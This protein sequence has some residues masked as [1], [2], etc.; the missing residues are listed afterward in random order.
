MND[1]Q[2]SKE[3]RE[4]FWKWC[5][6]RQLEKGSKGFHY[7]RDGRVMNWLPPGGTEWYQGHAALPGI[8]LNNLFEYAIPKLK[9]EYR[10]WKSILHDWIDGLTGDREKDALALFYAIWEA[11]K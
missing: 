5:G 8:N 9:A 7:E 11:I 1:T 6:W 2:P 3:Q 4:K 10:N